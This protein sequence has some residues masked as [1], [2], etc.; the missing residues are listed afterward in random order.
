MIDPEKVKNEV[1]G[2][3]EEKTTG[4]SQERITDIVKVAM[5]KRTYIS[6]PSEAP[7]GA[8]VQEGPQGGY[9]IED[10]QSTLD[11]HRDD[12]GDDGGSTSEADYD[13][14]ELADTLDSYD[15]SQYE[16]DMNDLVG[17]DPGE[18]ESTEE[19]TTETVDMLE[20][21]LAANHGEEAAEDFAH[22]HA[23]EMWEAAQ[24]IAQDY[25]DY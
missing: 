9:Y 17:R 15:T 13:E 16:M 3:T 19:F 4:L 5:G 21:I 22:E 25:L 2:S 18:F 14:G 11:D 20:E 24:G 6:D 12:G 10:E 23:D 8:N 1:F 7:E